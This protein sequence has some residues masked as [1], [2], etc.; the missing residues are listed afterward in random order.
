MIWKT[1]DKND[2]S[3]IKRSLHFENNQLIYKPPVNIWQPQVD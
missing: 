3:K 1:V 2:P